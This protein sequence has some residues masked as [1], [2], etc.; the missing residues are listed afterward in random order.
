MSVARAEAK[1]APNDA[2]HLSWPVR[3]STVVLEM[4]RAPCSNELRAAGRAG[5]CRTL[6]RLGRRY[7]TLPEGN[8]TAYEGPG[9]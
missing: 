3:A 5:E 7:G 1:P 2:L 6:D 9:T 8:A 4:E